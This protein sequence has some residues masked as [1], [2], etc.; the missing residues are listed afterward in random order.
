[1]IK[2][3][4]IFFS[5]RHF[6]SAT[7][8]RQINSELND[9][10]TVAAEETDNTDKE[11]LDYQWELVQEAKAHVKLTWFEDRI[12]TQYFE[13][14]LSMAKVARENDISTASIF[15]AVHRILSL[16]TEYIA[17]KINQ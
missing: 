8:Y 4:S 6:D 7:K 13:Q 11:L 17:E 10:V 14:N 15:N 5:N 3:K 2:G 12:A 9:T 1:M 16:Y